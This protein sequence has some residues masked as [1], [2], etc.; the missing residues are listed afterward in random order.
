MVEVVMC[1][2]RFQ[3]AVA[4]D[5]AA[6]VVEPVDTDLATMIGIKVWREKQT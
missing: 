1:K 6:V 5:A 3:V 2:Q 4:A